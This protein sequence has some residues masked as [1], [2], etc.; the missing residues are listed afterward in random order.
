[1]RSIFSLDDD[2]TK[3]IVSHRPASLQGVDVLLSFKN[4]KLINVIESS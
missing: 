4:G 3:I 2:M 1:M